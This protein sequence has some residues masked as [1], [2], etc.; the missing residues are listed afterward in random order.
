MVKVCHPICTCGQPVLVHETWSA[1]Y[2]DGGSVDSFDVDIEYDVVCD[3]CYIRAP[4]RSTY[5]RPTRA[6]EPT[7]DELPF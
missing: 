7:E 3:M 1:N 6:I 5:Q 4:H 2:D